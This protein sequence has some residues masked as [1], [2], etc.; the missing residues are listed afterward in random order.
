MKAQVLIRNGQRK[1]KLDREGITAISRYV[2]EREGLEGRWQLSFYFV[3]D[4]KSRELNRE[5]LRRDRPTDVLAFSMLEGPDTEEGLL[6]DVVVST[7]RAI[8]NA[9]RFGTS[10]E[11]EITRYVVHGVLHLLGYDDMGEERDRMKKREDVLLE[12]IRRKRWRSLAS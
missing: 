2:L 8:S 1:V 5:Y 12:G 11:E 3:G 9:E 10:A 6:G 7:H 4:S